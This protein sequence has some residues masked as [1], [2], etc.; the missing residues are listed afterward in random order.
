MSLVWGIILLKSIVAAEDV[1]EQLIRL[2]VIWLIVDECDL[3]LKYENFKNNPHAPL[4]CSR[5]MN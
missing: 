1:C 3:R 2:G 4:F 5:G